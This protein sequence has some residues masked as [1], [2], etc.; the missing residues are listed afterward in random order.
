[1]ILINTGLS[2][3]KIEGATEDGKQAQASHNH[4]FPMLTHPSKEEKGSKTD[5][6]ES[7]VRVKSGSQQDTG[8]PGTT[9]I[10]KCHYPPS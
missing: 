3:L 7:R 5:K 10:D 4:C 9:Q 1:V 2:R 6:N 8:Y